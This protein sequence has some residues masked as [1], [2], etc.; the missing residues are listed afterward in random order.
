MTA[1]CKHVSY[2][3]CIFVTW[4]RIWC[5][6]LKAHVSNPHIMKNIC[7]W[8]CW[9]NKVLFLLGQLTLSFTTLS[10]TSIIN[11]DPQIARQM[12]R[13]FM[14]FAWPSVGLVLTLKNGSGSKNR[15]TLHVHW[16]SITSKTK[17][18]KYK[19]TKIK[20]NKRLQKYKS[21]KIQKYKNTKLKMYKIYESMKVQNTVLILPSWSTI[22]CLSCCWWSEVRS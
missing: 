1:F 2:H 21:T 18:Q 11:T 15:I 16:C 12:S 7:I 8:Y 4:I 10:L 3:L 9:Q 13:L 6:V 19:S 14:T 17:I 5:E 20:E 22:R